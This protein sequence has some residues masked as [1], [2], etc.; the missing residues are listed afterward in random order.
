MT[1][2]MKVQRPAVQIGLIL[3]IAR[4]DRFE[5]GRA[6][7]PGTLAGPHTRSVVVALEI[8]RPEHPSDAVADLF[9]G[10]ARLRSMWAVAQGARRRGTILHLNPRSK[11]VRD[12]TPVA[13]RGSR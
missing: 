9:F 12:R 8:A 2:R 7:P 4:N 1:S 5:A 13:L 10:H 3:D 11:S 6:S